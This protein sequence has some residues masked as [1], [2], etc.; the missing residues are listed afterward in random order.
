MKIT[1][2]TKKLISVCQ[3]CGE[4]E[5]RTWNEKAL[6]INWSDGNAVELGSGTGST[7]LRIY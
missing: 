4:G 6:R 3:E 2:K 7:I 1:A 5:I